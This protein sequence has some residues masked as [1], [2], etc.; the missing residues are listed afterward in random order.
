MFF[1]PFGTLPF[2]V[3]DF[4]APAASLVDYQSADDSVFLFEID[5]S[6]GATVDPYEPLVF[7]TYTFGTLP[8]PMREAGTVSFYYSDR[9][10]TARPDDA[11]AP[12][13]YYEVRV[14]PIQIQQS[15]PLPPGSSRPALTLGQLQIDNTDGRFD[16]VARTLG[17]DL[18]PVRIKRL[19]SRAARY[20]EALPIF[21][22]VA[23]SNWL[24]SGNQLQIQLRDN[25]WVLTQNLLG[26]YQGGGGENGTDA[27]TG[28]PVMQ[29]YGR[30]RN[31][32]PQLVDPA[33]L[34]FKFHD[35]LAASVDAVRVRGADVTFGAAQST[36]AD[37]AAATVAGGTYQVALTE[38]GSYFRLGSSPDG[39]VTCDVHGDAVG[40]YT[41]DTASIVRR[42]LQRRLASSQLALDSFTSLSARLPGTIGVVFSENLTIQDAVQRVLTASYCYLIDLP[43]GRL[44]IDQLGLPGG[45]GLRIDNSLMSGDPVRLELPEAIAPCIWRISVAW[46]RN[47]TVMSDTD[48]VPAGTLT[49]EDRQQLKQAYRLDGGSQSDSLRLTRHPGA[50]DM[51]LESLF[52]DQGDAAALA[53]HIFAMFAPG[54][55]LWSVPLPNTGHRIGINLPVKL[56]HPRGGLS[57]GRDFRVCGRTGAGRAVSLLLFG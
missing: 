25:G 35:R 23:A 48:I 9:S 12:N 45:N 14:Q 22:G 37:L 55:E 42:I 24:A 21:S 50:V 36:Y 28:Q 29:I 56:T 39:I 13:R 41:D 16:S 47:W 34:I 31:A 54:R 49:E 6:G 18:R 8:Y 26:L 38:D 57:G 43:D 3:L 4:G 52:Y 15:S 51:V 19:P 11:A 40:G 10:W 46:R 33:K 20:D 1:G 53:E 2:G 17:V 7:G 30:V 5:A 27:M 44:K 32:S